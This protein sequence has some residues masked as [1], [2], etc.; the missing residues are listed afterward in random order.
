MKV[1][2]VTMQGSSF[3]NAFNSTMEL[4]LSKL[5][6]SLSFLQP[7]LQSVFKTSLYPVFAIIPF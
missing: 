2:D 5:S 3:I 6:P 7:V 4:L 1:L